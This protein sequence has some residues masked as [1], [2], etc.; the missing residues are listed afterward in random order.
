MSSAVEPVAPHVERHPAAG[1]LHGLVLRGCDRAPLLGRGC[2]P[3]E[4][5]DPAEHDRVDGQGVAADEHGRRAAA[6][7]VRHRQRRPDRV[8]V[9]AGH[10]GHR[11]GTGLVLAGGRPVALADGEGVH[12]E[13][14]QR[15]RDGD[16]HDD[17]A[18]L[19]ATA[20][21]EQ[22]GAGDEPPP[23]QE[24]A[25]ERTPRRTDQVGEQEAGEQRRQRRSGQR[26]R[27]LQAAAGERHHAGAHGGDHEGLHRPEGPR[28]RGDGSAAD[29]VVQGLAGRA[30]RGGEG[31]QHDGD[32]REQHRRREART[33]LEGR[34]ARQQ[35][36]DDLPA[37]QGHQRPGDHPDEE[38]GKE[39]EEQQGGRPGRP[40]TAQSRH[41]DLPASRGRRRRSARA[42]ARRGTA[43][44][45]A[46]AAAARCGAP[47]R[48]ARAGRRSARRPRCGAPGPPRAG[49][50]RRRSPGSPPPAP[51]GSRR[52]RPWCPRVRPPARSPR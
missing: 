43:R 23:A 4:E 31:G 49:P 20:G 3:G 19:G 14:R 18:S 28:G 5:R 52:R 24:A 32:Q 41:G 12:R 48:P 39:L 38:G 15:T 40:T 46:P 21:L 25:S 37:G 33:G 34:L 13:G 1:D 50:W 27:T 47:G 44:P 17:R 11:G 9:A 8:E 36:A 42:T 51:S 35:A 7:R 30:D 6:G 22:A 16:D 26:K 29:H 10:A 45:S 2:L